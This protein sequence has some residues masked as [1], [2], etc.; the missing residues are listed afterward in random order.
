MLL[1]VLTVTSTVV[2]GA[3]LATVAFVDGVWSDVMMHK[4][5]AEDQ[6]PKVEGAVPPAWTKG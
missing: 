6:A 3:T 2:V 1:Q 5:V 4:K